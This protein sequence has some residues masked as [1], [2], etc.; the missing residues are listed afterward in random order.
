MEQYVE[1]HILDHPKQ[2][3]SIQVHD[4][5]LRKAVVVRILTDDGDL[6]I[7]LSGYQQRYLREQLTNGVGDEAEE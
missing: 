3:V 1:G 2:G 6:S 5:L 7:V 4:N